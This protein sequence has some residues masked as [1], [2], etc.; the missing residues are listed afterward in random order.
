LLRHCHQR[1]DRD[2]NGGR[3]HH[4]VGGHCW[5]LDVVVVIVG[6]CCAINA[7]G[8]G[9]RHHHLVM[10]ALVVGPSSSS[11]CDN[12]IRGGMVAATQVVWLLSGCNN[13][14]SVTHQTGLVQ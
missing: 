10:G 3:C 1:W 12:N 14:G 6:D 11:G 13:A 8:G 2:G 5:G 9:S 7:G 4:H